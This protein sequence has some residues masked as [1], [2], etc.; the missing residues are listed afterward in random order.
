M[1]RAVAA[2]QFTLRVPTHKT[3][4]PLI[5]LSGHRPIQE[6]NAEALRN[7]VKSGPISP[8]RACAM[9]VRIP[10]IW[11]RSIPKARFNSARKTPSLDRVLVGGEAGAMSVAEAG[12]GSGGWNCSKARRISRSQSSISF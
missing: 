2:R 5:S 8:K 12:G 11:V 3:F 6:A 1:R 7:L 10:G 9:P 4:P